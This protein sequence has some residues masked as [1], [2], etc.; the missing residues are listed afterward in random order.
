MILDGSYSLCSKQL[1]TMGVIW[2]FHIN[3]SALTIAVSLLNTNVSRQAGRKVRQP[4][5]AIQ[6][7]LRRF[8]LATPA[9]SAGTMAYAY[10]C[11]RRFQ[12]CNFSTAFCKPLCQQKR[13]LPAA[14][15]ACRQLPPAA[16]KTPFA[17]ITLPPP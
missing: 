5:F 10:C 2:T 16:G 7:Y 17:Y 1:L 9:G 8:L 13:Q 15:P 4:Y 11:C 12:R 14:V 3:A 6:N